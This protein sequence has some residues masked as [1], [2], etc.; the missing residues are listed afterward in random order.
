MG[1][2]HVVTHIQSSNPLVGTLPMDRKTMHLAVGSP[3]G[4][5][6]GDVVILD[7]FERSG[8]GFMSGQRAQVTQVVFHA[9]VKERHCSF[10]HTHA[11]EGI[12]LC[13]Y[14]TT[15]HDRHT[16]LGE[17]KTCV[18]DAIGYV[19]SS[20]SALHTHTHTPFPVCLW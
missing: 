10:T 12:I 4:C 8:G 9:C 1:L 7:G 13:V 16:C 15:K 19:R 3:H 17:T 5:I 14:V 11:P 18:F 2:Q 6:E 20:S